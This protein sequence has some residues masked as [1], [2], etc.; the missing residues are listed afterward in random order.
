MD[1][2]SQVI[3]YFRHFFPITFLS[4]DRAEQSVKHP[5]VE[6]AVDPQPRSQQ[7]V[8]LFHFTPIDFARS[9]GGGGGG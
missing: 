4:E 3:G 8:Q 6:R 5:S 2:N 9:S 1:R 7:N